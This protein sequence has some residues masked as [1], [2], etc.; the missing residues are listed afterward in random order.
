MQQ[1]KRHRKA[2]FDFYFHDTRVSISK[3]KETYV[4]DILSG[5]SASLRISYAH[6]L[7]IEKPG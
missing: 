1:A 3:P 2:F 5:S 6:L 4:F 7:N